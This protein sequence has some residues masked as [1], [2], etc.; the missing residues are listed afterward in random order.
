MRSILDNDYIPPEPESSH[1]GWNDIGF[2]IQA[3][4]GVFVAL[5]VFN[6]LCFTH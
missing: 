6:V 3:A 5:S 1:F 2:I 4:I